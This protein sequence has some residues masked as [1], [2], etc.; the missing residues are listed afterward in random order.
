M[1]KTT[2]LLQLNH[3][4]CGRIE[5][6]EEALRRAETLLRTIYNDLPEWVKGNEIK[7]VLKFIEEVKKEDNSGITGVS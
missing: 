2:E 5:E 1:T 7:S 4:L 6:L 3:S